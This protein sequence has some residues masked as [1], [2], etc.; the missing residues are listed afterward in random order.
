[1][2]KNYSVATGAT[3]FLLRP[4]AHTTPASSTM[5][6][7]IAPTL[8]FLLGVLV[9]HEPFDQRRFIGFGIVWLALIIFGVEG[10]L[11][12]RNQPVAAVAD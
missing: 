12:H 2:H 3:G 6:T 9:Y 1:L 11:A 10:F 5:A 4:M 8:Q 7:I